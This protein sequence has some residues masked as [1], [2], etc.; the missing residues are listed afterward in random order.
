MTTA[1]LVRQLT[2]QV[3][4]REDAAPPPLVDA[5]EFLVSYIKSDGDPGDYPLD[6]ASPVRDFVNLR[7]R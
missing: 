1:E 5:L 7:H 4:L 3:T 2:R 6:W